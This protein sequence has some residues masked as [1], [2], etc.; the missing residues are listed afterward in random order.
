MVR[1]MKEMAL[2]LL[3]KQTEFYLFG[4]KKSKNINDRFI[5]STCLVIDPII[6][7]YYLDVANTIL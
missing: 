1:R 3:T 5:F 6:S 7:G 4:N 2:N